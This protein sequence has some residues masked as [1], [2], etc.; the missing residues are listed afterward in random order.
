MRNLP[1]NA[2]N[3]NEIGNYIKRLRLT[4]G[5]T[6][7]AL[8]SETGVSEATLSRIES[9]KSEVSAPHL[10]RLAQALKVD[11]A[12]F[13]TGSALPVNAGSRA[14]TRAGKGVPFASEFMVAK[15]LC[16]DLSR[17]AM[18]PFIDQIS[19]QTV[20]DAGGLTPHPGEEFLYVLTGYLLLHTTAYEPL[21]LAAGDCIYFDGSQPHAYVNADRGLCEILVV[22]SADLHALQKENSDE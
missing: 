4:T 8:A 11:I 10:Y 13:F 9:G 16:T 19:A 21:Q 14:V 17:K 6:L 7:A 18:H 15:V 1:A 12:D 5:Q 2:R 20:E 22:T 3:S